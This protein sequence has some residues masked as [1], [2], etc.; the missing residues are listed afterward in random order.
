MTRSSFYSDDGKNEP[1]D[2]LP[3]RLSTTC[4]LIVFIKN[5]E[6]SSKC[7]LLKR[8][9]KLGTRLATRIVIQLHVHVTNMLEAQ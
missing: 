2:L 6:L 1:P 9:Q 3:S 5:L 7:K 8:P 4:E